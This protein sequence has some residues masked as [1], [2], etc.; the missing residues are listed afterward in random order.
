MQMQRIGLIVNPMAGRDI[1]RLVARASLTSST[2]KLQAAR[3]VVAGAAQAGKVEV[4]L[5][6]DWEGMGRALQAEYP[7]VIR[8]LAPDQ[9]HP[10]SVSGRTQVW[11]QALE[12]DG[13]SVIM[14]IGGDGTQRNATEAMPE[15]PLLALAGGTNNV[16]CWLG[17]ETVAGYAAAMWALEK[18]ALEDTGTQ[19][20]VIHVQTERE[21]QTLALIDVAFVR[22]RY[23]GALAVWSASD[24]SQLLL[25]VADPARPGLSNVGGMLTRLTP[26]EDQGLE[27]GLTPSG[28]SGRSVPA[29]LAPGLMAVFS[30]QY[31]ERI[32]LGKSIFW[33]A[34]EGGSLALDGERTVVMAPGETV[35]LTIRRDGP[36]FL[37]PGRILEKVAG[38]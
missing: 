37:H 34:E 14:V 21:A 2:D 19:V 17:D 29:V 16:A 7:D 11:T 38:H 30:V 20:K 22:Q 26:E 18:P 12:A 35:S 6:D 27:V 4:V 13:V 8:L 36:W 32:A 15:I 3:R 28:A 24:V 1:R 10:T 25:A 5:N 23:T 33:K 31:V 9:S